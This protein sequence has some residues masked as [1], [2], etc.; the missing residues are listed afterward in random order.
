MINI[1]V[2]CEKKKTSHPHEL[3]I[4]YHWANL[5]PQISRYVYLQKKSYL[6]ENQNIDLTM[7]V[8]GFTRVSL[9]SN[10]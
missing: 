3:K 7:Y 10:K 5:F 8:S 4:T 9:S 6:R 1:Y 2:N